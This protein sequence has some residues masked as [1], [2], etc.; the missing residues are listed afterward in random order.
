MSVYAHPELLVSTEWLADHLA[1][2]AVRLIEIGA[3]EPTY[4]A[5]HIPGASH[6]PWKSSLWDRARRE[7]VLPPDF[8]A[9]LGRAGVTPETT[10]IFYSDRPQ[11]ATYALWSCVLR[12]H[13]QVK[14]LNG[15]RTRW[16]RE[17][18]PLTTERPVVTPTNYPLRPPDETGRISRG[19]VLAGLTD[20]DRVLL[21]GRSLEEYRGERVKP[22]PGFDHG[23]ERKGRIPGARHLPAQSLL[24]EDHTFKSA[25]ALRQAFE[26]R[27]ATPDK[28]V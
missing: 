18:R 17:G 16:L 15:S 11:F 23:A 8:A 26:A 20:P 4:D 9:L 12:G 10:L 2:P 14:I 24:N 13:T 21:D 25:D 5:G 7:F 3:F 1:D 6:W 28:D 22:A 27:G 19:G